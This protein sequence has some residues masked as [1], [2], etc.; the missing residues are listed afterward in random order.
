MDTIADEIIYDPVTLEAPNPVTGITV[1]AVDVSQ[2]SLE[3]IPDTEAGSILGYEIHRDGVPV[4]TTTNTWYTDTGLACDTTYTYQVYPFDAYGNMPAVSPQVQ[5]TTLIDETAPSVPDGLTVNSLSSAGTEISWLASTDN[6]KVAGYRIYRDGTYLCEVTDKTTYRDT[7]LTTGTAYR[8]TVSAYDEAG[9][10]SEQS[11]AV[12]AVPKNPLITK[13]T[14]E[15]Y[16]N[17]GNEKATLSV[18][19]RKYDTCSSYTVEID[20]YDAETDTWFGVNKSRIIPGQSGSAY[21]IATVDWDTSMLK[22]Y[23][24][25]VRFTVTDRDGIS[26]SV[27]NTYYVD[28][29]PPK[30][31]GNLTAQ[32]AQGVISLSWDVS[33]SADCTMYRVYRGAIGEEPVFL[34]ELSG[35]HVRTYTDKTAETGSAYIYAV[36]AVDGYGNESS[37]ENTVIAACGAD[38]EVPRMA[39]ASPAAGRVN[40]TVE[41]TATAKDNR[42]VSAVRYSYR[43]D[44]EEDWIF[45]DEETAVDGCATYAWDTTALADGIYYINMTAV[46]TA[47]NESTGIFTRRYEVDNSGPAKIILTGTNSGSTY[48]QLMWEDVT[49]TDFDCFVVEQYVN[50]RYIEAGREKNIL[51]YTVEHLTP[52]TEYSFRVVG[53]DNL[54]NR[55]EPSDVC[56][57]STTGDAIAP[58]ITAVYPASGRYRDS[59]PLSVTI[60]DN[61]AVS[62]VSIAYSYD[63]ENYVPLADVSA[64]GTQTN[65]TLAYDLNLADRPEGNI[66]IRYVAYD[67]AGNR[68]SLTSEGEEVVIGYVIDRTAPACPENLRADC[69]DGYIGLSWD[70][71]AEEDIAGYRLYRADAQTGIYTRLCSELTTVN[72][73][74]RNVEPGKAYLY[75]LE[76]YDTAGNVGPMTEA[77][78]ATASE[79]TTAPEIRGVSP[80]DGS[81]T[82]KNP[83][84]TVLA[85]DNSSLASIHLWYRAEG[86]DI[87][88]DAGEKNVSGGAEK[89]E[90]TLDLSEY[91]ACTYEV[92]AGVTDRSGNMGA[93]YE[94]TYTLDAD[95]PSSELSLETYDYA[96]G[97]NLTVPEAEDF[98]CFEIYRR[99]VED[100]YGVP[101]TEEYRC[102]GRMSGNTYRDK[103][104]TPLAKYEYEV[105]VYDKTGNYS[106]TESVTGYATDNDTE[107]PVA[108]LPDKM[109]VIAGMEF[110]PDGGGSHDN[111]RISDYAW[112]M[113][114]GGACTGMRPVYSYSEPGTYTVSL[115]VTDSSGNQGT[116]ESVVEV[117]PN[118][119]TGSVIIQVTDDNG[120]AMPYA[121]VYLNEGEDVSASYRTDSTGC[122]TI[123]AQ[124]GTYEVAAY[125]TG[126][127]PK[128]ITVEISSYTVN[129]Y[130]LMIPKGDIVVGELTVHRMN[131]QEI[132]DAGVDLS[133]PANLHTFT[134]TVTLTFEDYPIPINYIYYGEDFIQGSEDSG[135]SGGLGLDAPT[136]NGG[137]E[138]GLKE[139]YKIQTKI[140]SNPTE[141]GEPAAPV[142][143][144]YMRNTQT[145][146]WLKD[147]YMVELGVLNIADSKYVI[148]NSTATIHLPEG[149]SLA[150]TADGQSETQSMGS[151]AGQEKKYAS[152]VVKGDEPGKYNISADFTGNLTPFD[153]EINAHFEAEQIVEVTD[154]SGLHV[155]IKPETKGYTGFAY[156]IQYEITNNTG[157]PLYNFSTSLGPSMDP[158]QISQTYLVDIETGEKELISNY[159]SPARPTGL[160]NT[161]GQ[162]VVTQGDQKL[163]VPVFEDGET[164][165]GT[166]SAPFEGS[167]PSDSYYY[168]LIGSMVDVIEGDNLNVSVELRHTG[169]HISI[170]LVTYVNQSV[171]FTADPVN[172]TTGAYTDSCEALALSG[173]AILSLDMSYNSLLSDTAGEMGYGWSHNFE[174]YIRAEEGVLHYY[175]SPGVCASFMNDDNLNGIMYGTIEDGEIVLSD[176]VYG[177]TITYRSINAMM[178]DY[179]LVKHADG[180]YTMTTPG[181]YVYD[182]DAEGNL[183]HMTNAD[184]SAVTLTRTASQ[185]IVTEDKT[186]KRLILNY[187][188]GHLVSVAD[189]YGRS[190]TFTYNGEGVLTTYTNPLG[191]RTS[192]TYDGDGRLISAANQDGTVFVTNVYDETGRVI[193]Q[194]DAYGSETIFSYTDTEDG[195][196]TTVTPESGRQMRVETDNMCNITS[197]SETDG[198]HATYIYDAYGRKTETVDGDGNTTAYTYDEKD[199]ITGYTDSTGEHIAFSYDDMGNVTAITSSDKTAVMEY[200]STGKIT[201]A[202]D[203]DMKLYY[204]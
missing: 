183:S 190:S 92:R 73:Y 193:S 202:E 63:G 91:E 116:T 93:Y 147:M 42:A 9:N 176:Q 136:P 134:F 185:T 46:D 45:L 50:G 15:D 143:F 20:Y 110:T 173:D 88:N 186:G 32:D 5:A 77:V 174:S 52:G 200:D 99:C 184:G 12:E 112:D 157:K 39:D 53:Y 79:D 34:A 201:Y 159:A 76:P 117:L 148:E 80:A 47:G 72:Y 65:T 188:D 104:V 107:A 125:Q 98:Y 64:S 69:G 168:E 165:Y 108:V 131:L 120:V 105:R 54:G 24:Y 7:A 4:A 57:V 127:I 130:T 156:Y 96:I 163:S 162:T 28:N 86:E 198:L 59:I 199:R 187:A 160:S 133:D 21:C 152:W 13:V 124:E 151:L 58:S 175:T 17:L 6:K 153:T 189:D 10:E 55:G 122:V 41:I 40:G 106:T 109:R 115:T 19:F 123:A 179:V 192:Y 37:R 81:T 51:G 170:N 38:T 78:A 171:V 95:A 126:Y 155:L 31:P 114:D 49:E 154:F 23:D 177:D 203:G 68:S 180:S 119:G 141:A 82:G 121:Y 182:Y 178:K 138:P 66:Y 71:A 67:K 56:R 94:N 169:E 89:V 1:T 97:V 161:C 100:A 85:T 75:K 61:Y 43:K 29:Q 44:G 111:S 140:V 145:V 118:T 142:L 33:V 62:R 83:T 103:T 70:G 132:V 139:K 74:D 194:K 158:G 11:Q 102:L 204:G 84:I 172:V 16:S 25:P 137:K 149:M 87:W 144:A 167:K 101:Q 195:M 197:V 135:N 22:G 18:T 60:Q 27:T 164:I 30:S 36:T 129:T 8:Y 166:W 128:D 191:E 3:Y 181:G 2:V 150:V 90:F 113:G 26:V 196:I 146:S 35:A 48:I 14:P